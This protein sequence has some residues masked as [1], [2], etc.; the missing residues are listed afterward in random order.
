MKRPRT[1]EN[2]SRVPPGGKQVAVGTL[3]HPQPHGGMPWWS[4]LVGLLAALFV[5]FEIYSPAISGQFIFDDHYLPFLVP[6][7]ADSPLRS[8]M[9]VRPL[10]MITYWLN[11]QNSGLEPYG[12]HLVNI[13]LHVCNAVLAWVIVRRYL[14]IAGE[15]SW[16]RE[17]LAIFAGAVFLT[18]PV[19]TESVAYVVG[20]SEGLSILLCLSALAVYLYRKT[21]EITW[22]R[23]LIVIALFG[24]ACTVK[25]HTVVLP[26][27]LVL[28]DF[29]FT[30]PFRLTGAVRNWRLYGPIVVVGA[31]GVMAVIRVLRVAESAGFRVKEFT[32]YQYLFSQFRAIWLYLRLYVFPV[33]QNGDYDWTASKTLFDQGAVF[34]LIG[35]LAL[36]ALA[37]KYRHTYP[38]A[39]YGFI[40]FLI[41]L[42]PTSSVV[43]IRDIA[44]E[45]RLYLPFICLLL[46]TVDLLRRWKVSKGALVGMMAAVVA[47][48]SV[49]TYQRNQV[50]AGPTPFW[51]DVTEKSPHNARAWFQ[52]AY[53]KWQDGQCQEAS[54]LYDKVSKMQE[55]DDRLL[56]D[57]ALALECSG[58]PDEAVAKLHQAAAKTP[59]AHIYASIG[60]IHGKNGKDEA[61][62][63][64]LAQ[65]EKID[66]RYEMIYVYRGNIYLGRGD[67]QGA[68]AEYN[69]ALSIN[70]GNQPAREALARAQTL[71]PRGT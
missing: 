70:G 56:V 19:Q 64:A 44:A 15:Q 2:L 26:V 23:A 24:A 12:Y 22:G 50:W 45:R 57:W 1:S 27:L 40:G 33:N 3:D 42:A 49:L 61:S 6:E 7:V 10:L 54:N 14:Q 47:V 17:A 11:Y 38:L 29:Y 52:L 55:Q 67:V 8:W 65:A 71:L 16:M 35:I 59:T 48:C 43:P 5:A 34:G 30:T 60:M 58:K 36:L 41:L 63:S 66:P 46:I 31:L 9:G 25:E 68:I 28:T 4:Y 39:S 37:W 32:W 69:R 21:E 51:A 20:R 13:L 62:L 53:A 18:H